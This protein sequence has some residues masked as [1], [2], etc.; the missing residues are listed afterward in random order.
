MALRTFG[1]FVQ[2]PLRKLESAG[3]T[4]RWFDDSPV[5][6][7]LETAQNM[8]QVVDDPLGWLVNCACNLVNCHCVTQQQIN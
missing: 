3:T 8:V 1:G 5:F 6:G 4:T 7:M 2:F